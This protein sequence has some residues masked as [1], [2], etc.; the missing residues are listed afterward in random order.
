MKVAYFA[1]LPPKRTG[2]GK[3]AAELA[4]ALSDRVELTFFDSA[5]SEPP[6]GDR[7]IVDYVGRPEALLDVPAYDAALYQFGNNP[8]FHADIL[9]AFLVNPGPVVLHDTVLYFLMAG[10]GE[11]G[12]LREFLFNYGPGRL[13]EFFAIARESPGHDVLRYPAPE[14]YP[15]LRRIAAEAPAIVV[16]SAAS[17]ATVRALSPRGPVHVIPHLAYPAM[18]EP[19]GPTVREA[20]R[21]ELGIGPDTVVFG[22]FGF[23]GPTKRLPSVLAA[24]ARMGGGIDFRLLIVGEGP[25]PAGDIAAH[26]LGERVIK[27]GFVDEARFDAL[28]RSVDVL[29]NLRFPSMGET[30][31]PQ[32]Q[33]MA[34]GLPSVVTGQ[35]WFAELPDDAAI[36]VAADADEVG[37][38]AEAL[39]LLA[40]DGEARARMGRAARDYVMQSCAPEA[41]AARYAQVL[42]EA[43]PARGYYPQTAM[44]ADRVTP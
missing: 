25:D 36:K 24:L 20:T 30:S 3:Y 8:H 27:T 16:H 32:T 9:R 34:A 41:V 14:R 19:V 33:A 2:V 5:P 29:V 13:A 22:S 38:L 40:T 37:R 7:P 21:A 35:G 44:S 23:L 17:A 26:G 15:M 1:P 18:L 12:R 6:T 31:G 11:G 10:L 28:L 4:R 42:S 43:G 39:A